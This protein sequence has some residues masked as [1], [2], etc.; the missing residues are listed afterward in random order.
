MQKFAE[1]EIGSNDVSPETNKRICNWIQDIENCEIDVTPDILNYNRK[2]NKK[3]IH[4]NTSNLP[5]K[6]LFIVSKEQEA[7]SV[8]SNRTA[9]ALQIRSRK[10]KY[11]EIKNAKSLNTPEEPELFFKPSKTFNDKE[12][13][14]NERNYP[15]KTSDTLDQSPELQSNKKRYGLSENMSRL[16]PD[17]PIL[18]TSYALPTNK[19]FNDTPDEPILSTNYTSTT[20][21]KVNV[22][23]EEP[24]LF[25]NLLQA[26]K[27]TEDLLV[28]PE[29]KSLKTS[30]YYDDDLLKTPELSEYTMSILNIA[31]RNPSPIEYS[32]N[33]TPSKIEKE[34][35]LDESEI[36]MSHLK[37]PWHNPGVK[38][39]NFYCDVDDIPQS[40]Q[41]SDVTMNILKN[42]R[43]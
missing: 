24:S 18:S 7:E 16:T 1:P 37:K 10:T 26:H 38:M 5:T 17:E 30:N 22:T 15:L 21:K 29:I 14:L 42:F 9:D 4:S 8:G 33:K 23:P 35:R 43:V 12:Y 2:F 36:S 20:N 25:G 27:K 41:L 19:K 32:L 11:E 34:N 3:Q 39:E 6:N 13:Y 28:E 40:P 31:K